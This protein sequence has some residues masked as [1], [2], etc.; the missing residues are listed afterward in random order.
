MDRSAAEE[1]LP[2]KGDGDATVKKR[3]GGRAPPT[4]LVGEKTVSIDGKDDAAP[5]TISATS[6]H[7][8]I[9]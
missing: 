9:V 5:R 6:V 7:D 4:P 2:P 3:A 1:R 8:V